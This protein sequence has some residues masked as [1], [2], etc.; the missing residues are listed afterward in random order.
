MITPVILTF[1]E[2]CNINSTLSSLQWAQRIVVLDSGSTD[3][4]EH[5]A[6]SFKNASW[7]LRP[8]DNHRAQW[9]YAIH[10][11]SIATDYVLA[12]DADMRPSFGFQDELSTFVN[13]GKF[14]GAWIPFE[15]RIFGQ[16][17]M[18]SIYPAQIRLFHKD[19]VRILQPGHTQVFEID[20]ELCRFRAQLIH[21]DLKPINR[22]LSNQVN[23]AS[24]EA[25]R[26]A[27]S[28]CSFKDLL[29][30]TGISPFVVGAWAY[31]R[32]G[33]P[34]RPAVAKAYACER[35]IFEAIL[36][37]MLAERAEN[38][39][40]KQGGVLLNSTVSKDELKDDASFHSLQDPS[41]ESRG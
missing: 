30:S 25:A 6:R 16:S 26:I 24:L 27:A 35:M 12:L 22:W 29:R 13:S 2:A 20:G 34:F 8:F 36:A 38:T 18:G 11:T 41:T 32:A 17:L 21:E 19:Q 15:Y 1:N 28:Q 40:A 37:R 31:F 33:G 7:F 3:E 4:T 23:Y 39:S 5:I 10:Q 9:E 14:A